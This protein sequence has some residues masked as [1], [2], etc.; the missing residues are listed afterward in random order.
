MQWR[1]AEGRWCLHGHLCVAMKLCVCHPLNVP[2]CY[3]VCHR[4]GS[5]GISV[6]LCDVC[7]CV[8]EHL[9]MK[10]WPCMSMLLWH[11]PLL[12]RCSSLLTTLTNLCDQPVGWLQKPGSV[13]SQKLVGGCEGR[14]WAWEVALGSHSIQRQ[15]GQGSPGSHPQ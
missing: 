6:Y 15:G 8:F 7:V 12:V 10:V 5:L 11:P 9:D 1:C 13:Q 3:T 2:R 4:S 14:R